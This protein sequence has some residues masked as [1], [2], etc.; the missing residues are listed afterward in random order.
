V[1]VATNISQ[2]ADGLDLSRQTAL[3]L[4]IEVTPLLETLLL[5]RV[6]QAK[7]HFIQRDAEA[8]SG[9]HHGPNRELIPDRCWRH[10]LGEV[11]LVCPV[12]RHVLKSIWLQ[13]TFTHQNRR[14]PRS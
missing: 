12:G 3:R 6:E 8:Q 14:L 11:P 13:A 10:A 2:P 5:R 4:S 1:S 9:C 7:G